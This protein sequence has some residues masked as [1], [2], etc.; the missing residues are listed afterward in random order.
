MVRS[1]YTAVLV[2]LVAVAFGA[3]GDDDSASDASTTA[4]VTQPQGTTTPPRATGTTGTQRTDTKRT[5]K[6]KERKQR[7]S[8][9]S[10]S[11]SAAPTTPS[12]PTAREKPQPHTL[13]PAE[14]KQVG[15]QQ[16]EQARIL[17]KAATLEG[18]AKRYGIKNPEPSEVAKA[19]AAAYLVGLRDY[20]ERGCKAGL[21][22]GEAGG[23]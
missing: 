20:V 16:Y 15:K 21:R 22:E 6:S 18:L 3:C 2:A 11:G 7:D 10:K 19:Y 1:A 17:C 13:T 4:G 23:Q 9:E 8:G 5:T 12:A 14:L